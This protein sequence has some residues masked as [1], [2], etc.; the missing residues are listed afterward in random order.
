MRQSHRVIRNFHWTAFRQDLASGGHRIVAISRSPQSIQECSEARFGDY[1]QPESLARA[2]AGLDRL[3]LIPSNETNPGAR[4][5]QHIAAV[6]AATAAGVKHIVLI[7]AAGT[8]EAQEPNIWSAYYLPEQR[9]MRDA[10][11][12]SILRM[13]YYIDTFIDEVRL[14]LP[15]GALAGLAE[16]RAAFVARDDVASAAAAILLGEG[17]AGAIYNATGPRSY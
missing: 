14:S 12:W 2:Y 3:V 7:S 1:N 8:R 5:G 17:H 9:L 6:D 13:N 4:L 10:A 15:N 11:R 16:H